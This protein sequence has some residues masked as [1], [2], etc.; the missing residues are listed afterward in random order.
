[1]VIVTT[2][3]IFWRFYGNLGSHIPPT[4]FDAIINFL[5]IDLAIV[6]GRITIEGNFRPSCL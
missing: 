1:M 2:T 5:D 3:T 4:N 6:A